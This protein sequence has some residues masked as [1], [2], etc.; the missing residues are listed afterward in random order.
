[1]SYSEEEAVS[2]CA[3]SP[4]QSLSSSSALPCNLQEDSPGGKETGP[5]SLRLKLATLGASLLLFQRQEA[6]KPWRCLFI[7]LFT[8]AHPFPRAHQG[9]HL[10][11]MGHSGPPK[12]Q[13]TTLQGGRLAAVLGSKQK[14][15]TK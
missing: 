11:E 13:E 8:A 10:G 12:A 7:A 4:S 2:S 9:S 1:M 6:S 5:L 14:N 15:K 3:L